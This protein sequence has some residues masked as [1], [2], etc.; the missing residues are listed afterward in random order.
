M[1]NTF[2]N[3][4]SATQVVA[5][6]QSVIE[7]DNDPLELSLKAGDVD[8]TAQVMRRIGLD[9]FASA[10]ESAASSCFNEDGENVPWMVDVAFRHAV[11]S[12]YTNI[13]L[14]D[15]LHELFDFVMNT[16][17]VDRVVARIDSDQ[18]EMLSVAVHRKIRN[19]LKERYSAR[20]QEL[21]RALAMLNFIT[22][23]YNEI[24]IIFGE[25]MGDDM[26]ELMEK[27]RDTARDVTG[28][29]SEIKEKLGLEESSDS[30]PV[31][32]GGDA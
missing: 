27:L 6:T 19:T 8:I 24:G 32:K 26:K 13:E 1:I 23:K 7:K 18:F 22:Q 17:V 11:L 15:D 10:V 30:P 21:D 16:D 4:V 5:Y 3:T 14:P 31:D 20:E 29:V 2:N 12:A 28:E 9:A 25:I